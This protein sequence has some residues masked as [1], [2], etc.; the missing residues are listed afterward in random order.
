MEYN[1]QRELDTK[2]ELDAPYMI[3]EFRGMKAETIN[4]RD[5]KTGEANSMDKVTYS[6]EFNN[7]M[8]VLM[9]QAGRDF[10]GVYPLQRGKTYAFK[11]GGYKV[12]KGQVTAMMAGVYDL[13]EWQRSIN[14]EGSPAPLSPAPAP[15]KK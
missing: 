15:A 8:S 14:P 5:K 1:K 6:L 12:E 10:Q 11:L 7:G 4:W 3:A 9:G 13:E 2:P